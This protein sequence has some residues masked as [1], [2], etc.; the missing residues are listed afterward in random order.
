M[1]LTGLTKSPCYLALDLKKG[2]SNT[3]YFMTK[4]RSFTNGT[5][6]DVTHDFTLFVGKGS[7][8]ISSYYLSQHFKAGGK[9]ASPR[10]IYPIFPSFSHAGKLWAYHYF[11]VSRSPL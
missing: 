8:K 1:K 4:K 2:P 6:P 11:P 7:G 10:G 9:R 5:R 3:G